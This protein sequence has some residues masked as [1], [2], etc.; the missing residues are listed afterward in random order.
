MFKRA[1]IK[2]E[3]DNKKFIKKNLNLKFYL[4]YESDIMELEDQ[5]QEIEDYN[6]GDDGIA[7]R[8][9]HINRD[10]HHS[11]GIY[12]D[13]FRN[14]VKK[15][16][17]FNFNFFQEYDTKFMDKDFVL[18]NVKLMEKKRNHVSK[19]SEFYERNLHMVIMSE[20]KKEMKEKGLLGD[21]MKIVKIQFSKKN[22]VMVDKDNMTYGSFIVKTE[23]H[24]DFSEMSSFS[25]DI[26]SFIKKSGLTRRSKLRN[27]NI[28]R[29]KMKMEQFKPKMV[30]DDLRLRRNKS[31]ERKK[32]RF[33]IGKRE[34]ESDIGEEY[35]PLT[36]PQ[37]SRRVPKF[38]KK[39]INHLENKIKSCEKDK[40]IE[41]PM[42][43]KV[44]KVS[45]FDI[46]NCE[47]ISKKNANNYNP[48]GVFNSF[49][50][51]SLKSKGYSSI[52]INSL[53]KKKF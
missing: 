30:K 48:F 21:F 5:L 38:S 34:E 20:I 41:N 12:Q 43:N 19:I 2:G 3:I 25:H 39:E 46:L 51:A 6:N 29:K 37:K 7:S 44:N 23:V 4:K 52:Q 31:S 26:N 28:K 15:L 8:M 49:N 36:T 13:S 16:Y 42:E 10:S 35:T 14:S 40:R 27:S 45:L 47:K 1:Q 22:E 33:E 9:N 50:K 17:F 18:N 11:Y 32:G 24:D 53:A